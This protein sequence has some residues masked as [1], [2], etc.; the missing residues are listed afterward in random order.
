[1]A[2]VIGGC[3]AHHPVGAHLGWGGAGPGAAQQV[4]HFAAAADRQGLE[5]GP[6]RSGAI[7]GQHLIAAIG[8]GLRGHQGAVGQHGAV[9]VEVFKRFVI[10]HSDVVLRRD[11]PQHA[12]I[13]GLEGNR[14]THQPSVTDQVFGRID[15]VP[16]VGAVGLHVQRHHRIAV[17]GGGLT[18]RDLPHGGEHTGREQVVVAA[19]LPI[20]PA[21]LN[22]PPLVVVAGGALEGSRFDVGSGEQVNDRHRIEAQGR[23]EIELP[24]ELVEGQQ[25]QP[26]LIGRP[27]PQVLRLRQG[28][29][30]EV[31]PVKAPLRRRQ[32]ACGIDLLSAHVLPGAKHRAQRQP[33]ED[34]WQ[35]MGRPF[36]GLD[37]AG[38]HVAANHLR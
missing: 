10:G 18:D 27:L 7:P 2:A 3:D 35:Q 16:P 22:R 25:V 28:A 33:G 19:L 23:L 30:E 32:E 13:G 1:M 12:G 21:H 26:R 9:A 4:A 31:A 8:Q 5:G 15:Q 24:I 38:T 20:Q 34:V 36:V 37:V 11:R 14:I 29:I 6:R 17:A